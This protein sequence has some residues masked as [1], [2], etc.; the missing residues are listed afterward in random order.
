MIEYD[1]EE[2]VSRLSICCHRTSPLIHLSAAK[3]RSSDISRRTTPLVDT[4]HSRTLSLRSCVC[5]VNNVCNILL[6]LLWEDVAIIMGKDFCLPSL[7]HVVVRV[8]CFHCA[9]KTHLLF[10]VF[11]ELQFSWDDRDDAPAAALTLHFAPFFSLGSAEAL[12]FIPAG[13]APGFNG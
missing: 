6:L 10:A 5:P 11:S 12:I 1:V 4:A 2:P 13:A 3:P 9:T 7:Q 8:R